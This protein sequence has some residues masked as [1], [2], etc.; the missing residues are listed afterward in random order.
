MSSLEKKREEFSALIRQ[1]RTDDL[2]Q[3]LEA[4]DVP[5]IKHAMIVL[6]FERRIAEEP[7]AAGPYLGIAEV[8]HRD[9]NYALSVAYFEK[10]LRRSPDDIYGLMT[11]ARLRATCPDPKYRDGEL[12][13]LDARTALQIAKET[14]KADGYRWLRRRFLQIL[15]AAHAETGDFSSALDTLHEALHAS[16]TRI[17]ARE[18]SEC[19]ATIERGKPIRDLRGLLPHAY[20]RLS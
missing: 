14:G 19:I 17:A 10:G 11:R 7:D 4:Q 6:N 3:W 5:Y 16:I 12:A 15:A 2:R 13:L 9:G 8:L 18:V 1:I 20:L